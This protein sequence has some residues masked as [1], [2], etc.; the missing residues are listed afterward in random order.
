[1]S[2]EISLLG[3]LWDTVKPHISQKEQVEVAEAFLRLFDEHV[4]LDDIDAYKHEFDPSLKAAIVSYYEDYD[5]DDD[6]DE[7]GW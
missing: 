1:M 3:E 7:Y 6:D 5:S 4:G 2:P